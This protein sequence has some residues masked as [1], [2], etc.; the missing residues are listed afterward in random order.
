M[1]NN[2]RRSR[3]KAP[4]PSTKLSYE[5]PTEFVDLPS[6]GKFYTQ[7]HPFHNKESVEIRFMTAKDE[8]ILSSTSLIEQGVAI[9]RFL[10]NIIVGDVDVTSLLVGDQS[11]IM[12]AARSSGY[13][14]FYE[15][16]VTCPNCQTESVLMFDLSEKEITGRCFDDQYVKDNNI[17]ITADGLVKITLPVTKFEVHLRML[18]SVEQADFSSDLMANKDTIITST[19]NTLIEKIN[20]IDDREQVEDVISNLPAKDS[21]Y[22]RVVYPKLVPNVSL[23]KEF[24]CGNCGTIS[25]MEV[26]LTAAFFWPK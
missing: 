5:V 1:R 17:Q 12:I 10:E 3:A 13:G 14:P 16:V 25:N 18:T 19:L 4:A 24:T 22:V 9:E 2:Q 7:E 6:R 8:D 26:P 11:A 23:A 20:G 21:R 15:T